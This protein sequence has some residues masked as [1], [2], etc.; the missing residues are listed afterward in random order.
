MFKIRGYSTFAERNNMTNPAL[1]AIAESINT[2]Q[3]VT[4]QSSDLN[5]EQRNYLFGSS[6]MVMT[7]KNGITYQDNGRAEGN[8]TVIV[9]DDPNVG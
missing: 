7:D 3:P 6:S 9:M 4:L 8:W 5:E 1:R 2:G